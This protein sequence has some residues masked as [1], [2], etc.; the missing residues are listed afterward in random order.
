M[1]KSEFEKVKS[2]KAYK[3]KDDGTI[4]VKD[5]LYKDHWKVYKDKKFKDISKGI[6]M[7]SWLYFNLLFIWIMYSRRITIHQS[8]RI[9]Y[10]I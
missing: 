8:Y 3:K 2:I 9:G 7:F 4:C 1:D 10:Y 6:L 5:L